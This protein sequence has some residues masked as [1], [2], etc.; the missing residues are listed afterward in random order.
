MTEKEKDENTIYTCS[1]CAKKLYPN[2]G[3]FT[4]EQIM[5]ATYVKTLFREEGKYPEHM[6]V[7]IT[8]IVMYEPCTV[9]G[10]LANDPVNLTKI[11]FGDGVIVSS[12]NIEDL[13]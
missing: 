11:A 3:K 4:V 9:K 7:K 13:R 2:K 12:K 8:D 6:W 1:E 5:K 10:T